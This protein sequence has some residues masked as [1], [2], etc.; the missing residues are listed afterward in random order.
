MYRPHGRNGNGLLE[1]KQD[2]SHRQF[3]YLQ[4]PADTEW[5]KEYH[6]LLNFMEKRLP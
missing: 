2:A 4:E 3:T 5:K 1:K 6:I